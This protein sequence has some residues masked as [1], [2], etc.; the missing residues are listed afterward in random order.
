MVKKEVVT[1][2]IRPQPF[3]F[4]D[5][6]TADVLPRTRR[7]RVVQR[8]WGTGRRCR[9]VAGGPQRPSAHEVDADGGVPVVGG[10]LV[11]GD[12]VGQVVRPHDP[13][14]HTPVAVGAIR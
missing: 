5:G 14:P 2:M 12:Q 3:A 1:V 11:D 8:R 7:H 9:G 10:D 13:H 4:I 6:T